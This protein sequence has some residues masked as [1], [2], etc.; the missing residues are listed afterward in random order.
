MDMENDDPSKLAYPEEE[1]CAVCLESK[2]WL[3][4]LPCH[5]CVCET[6][7]LNLIQNGEKTRTFLC[8]FC[9]ASYSTDRS[10]L[11]CF[12]KQILLGKIRCENC[13][14]FAPTRETMWCD[15]CGE[16]MCTDCAL[17]FHKHH[18]L[19][20]WESA[21]VVNRILDYVRN[22]QRYQMQSVQA[23]KDRI[24]AEIHRMLDSVLDEIIADKWEKLTVSAGSQ[25][26]QSVKLGK[27]LNSVLEQK[28]QTTHVHAY[29]SPRSL[30][31]GLI[32]LLQLLDVDEYYL[33]IAD[34]MEN[35]ADLQLSCTLESFKSFLTEKID[36]NVKQADKTNFHS[37]PLPFDQLSIPDT[38][39]VANKEF[40]DTK[41]TLRNV[42][43]YIAGPEH[44]KI[45]TSPRQGQWHCHVTL[46]H[47]TFKEFLG[48]SS[49]KLEAEAN[50]SLMALLYLQVQ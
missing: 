41:T 14:R 31:L 44:W 39:A 23:E 50:A 12:G 4:D 15:R 37:I 17:A 2:Q 33:G 45:R 6:C 25:N 20:E 48:E 16:A 8:P 29:S 34:G 19:F 9:R 10:Q 49:N 24:R 46:H 35:V 21:H 47:P 13:N 11:S 42:M 7:L 5:H 30:H 36:V 22:H 40:E 26:S 32:R 28:A 27:F 38:S 1:E 18:E 3:R 43:N